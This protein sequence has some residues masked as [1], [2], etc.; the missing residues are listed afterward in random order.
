MRLLEKLA[1]GDRRSIGR[2]NEVVADVLR[3]PSLFEVLF[4]GLRHD[5]LL[6]RMRAA[7]A[8]EKITVTRPEWL[9]AHKEEL[10]GPLAASDQQE[11]RWHVAQ[12]LPRLILSPEERHRAVEILKE[13][14]KD[15]SSIVKTCAMQALADLAEDDDHLRTEVIDLLQTLR[16][17]GTPA[18]KS[19]GRRLLGRL[20]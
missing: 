8:V 7:D 6:I 16:R 1:G 20:E 18:M 19:R 4:D 2:S 17:S 5:D 14:L 13:Y 15:K 9:G 10:L 12:M 11:V 3:D